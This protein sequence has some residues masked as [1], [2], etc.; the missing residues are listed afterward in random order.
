MWGALAAA[1]CW[2]F[3]LVLAEFFRH[4]G[5]TDN[6]VGDKDQLGGTGT[7]FAGQ[8]MTRQSIYAD[9]M[10]NPAAS[11]SQKAYA[12]FRAVHCYEPAHSNDCG[13]D[14]VPMATRKGWYN[15]LKANYGDT[16][17]AK[18]LRYYW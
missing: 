2:G 5:V 14:D 7:I 1:L 12:L 15:E 10:K 16:P 6:K 4:S 3:G 18:E 8:P 11:H 9:T 13:G 17:W